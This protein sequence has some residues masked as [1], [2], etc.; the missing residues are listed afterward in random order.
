MPD[1]IVGKPG[2]S[3]LVAIGKRRVA[4]E[5]PVPCATCATTVSQVNL[6]VSKNMFDAT[7]FAAMCI[8]GTYVIQTT[9]HIIIHLSFKVF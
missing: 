7:T 6:C 1:M 8:S 3:P 9:D 5:L 4:M 2:F